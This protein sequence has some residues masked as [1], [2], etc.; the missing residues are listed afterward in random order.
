MY[1]FQPADRLARGLDQ[2]A[3]DR[4]LRHRQFIQ[5]QQ[6]PDGGFR[7]REG[8]SD[9]YYTGFAVRALAVSGGIDDKTRDAVGSFLEP[10]DPLRLN[11]IDLLSWLYSAL[12]VQAAGGQAPPFPQEHSFVAFQTLYAQE[13]SK[14]K[15]SNQCASY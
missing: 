14:T 10:T 13:T 8:E 15:R 4:I 2:V 12:V 3:A 7:G 5:T 9:L 1:L 6:M 11:V